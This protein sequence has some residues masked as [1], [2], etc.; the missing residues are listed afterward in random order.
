MAFD[1]PTTWGVAYM[2]YFNQSS[3]YIKDLVVY[4]TSDPSKI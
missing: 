4:P 1:L 3:I 2:V